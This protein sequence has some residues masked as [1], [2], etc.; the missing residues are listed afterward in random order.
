GWSRRCGGRWAAIDAPTPNGCARSSLRSTAPRGSSPTSPAGSG[1]TD[2]LPLR[3][4]SRATRCT[5]G[6]A[7]PVAAA[8][9]SAGAAPPDPARRARAGRRHLHVAERALG[10]VRAAG[11]G[12]LARRRGARVRTQSVFGRLRRT[13]V[14][15]RGTAGGAPPAASPSTVFA[16]S[17]SP[18]GASARVRLGRGPDPEQ[19]RRWPQAG[20]VATGG[21]GGGGSASRADRARAAHD[22]ANARRRNAGP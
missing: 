6:P 4:H 2:A 21:C 22:P 15:A 11:A 16:D 8:G 1:A 20:A 13:G 5:R 18:A 9:D 17:L 19:D 10:S 12:A 14:D 7:G 3:P